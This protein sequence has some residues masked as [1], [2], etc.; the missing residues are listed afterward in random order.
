MRPKS[1]PVCN[2]GHTKSAHVAVVVRGCACFSC[3]NTRQRVRPRCTIGDCF[4]N[5]FVQR[6]LGWKVLVEQH[7]RAKIFKFWA[8]LVSRGKR[9]LVGKFSS[10]RIANAKAIQLATNMGLLNKARKPGASEDW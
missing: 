1:D 4:C 3:T 7:P 6:R 10:E 9:E 2:C 8:Y 5:K